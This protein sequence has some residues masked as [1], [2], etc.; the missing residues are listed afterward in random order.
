MRE[1]YTIANHASVHAISYPRAREPS[2]YCIASCVW[3]LSAKLPRA[4]A[5]SQHSSLSLHVD[6]PSAN[7]QPTHCYPPKASC[8]SPYT[9]RLWRSPPLGYRCCRSLHEQ[10]KRRQG[11]SPPHLRSSPSIILGRHCRRV[12]RMRLSFRSGR[13]LEEDNHPQ[14]TT[15][16]LHLPR[17]PICW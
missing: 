11:S 7:S 10:W 12:R 16:S 6:Q 9:L 13:C 15:H 3:L 14:C 8:S 2:A 4:A 17:H 1:C 5:I